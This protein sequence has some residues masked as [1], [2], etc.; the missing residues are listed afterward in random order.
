MNIIL[1][2]S[3]LFVSTAISTCVHHKDGYLKEMNKLTN[4]AE[5]KVIPDTFWKVHNETNYF[6]VRDWSYDPFFFHKCVLQ[7]DR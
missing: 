6:P 3:A 4:I 7:S 1:L 5:S 2:Y